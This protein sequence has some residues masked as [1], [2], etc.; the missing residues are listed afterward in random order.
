M[1]LGLLPLG[2][3]GWSWLGLGIIIGAIDLRGF[4]SCFSVDI[5]MHYKGFLACLVLW[6]SRLANEN[7]RPPDFAHSSGGTV[8]WLRTVRS[9]SA[10]QADDIRADKAYARADR[11][12]H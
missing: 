2:P 9:C 5:G 6:K 12:T 4:P 3:S 8:L 11:T 1:G 7:A 10:F